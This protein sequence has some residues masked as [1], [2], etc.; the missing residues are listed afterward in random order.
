MG[1][2]NPTERFLRVALQ[3]HCS[4]CGAPPTA[5][6]STIVEEGSGGYVETCPR[7][8]LSVLPALIAD[9]LH[10]LPAG[11][12]APPAD[13]ALREIEA[14]FWRA[15]ALRLVR[16]RKEPTMRRAGN[17][18]CPCC[19]GDG[20]AR[21]NWCPICVE[22]DREGNWVRAL[23]EGEFNSKEQSQDGQ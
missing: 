18:N 9:A 8:A 16:E 7:C 17:V 19:R 13:E 10:L 6:W 1:V 12:T 11:G 4:F 22:S 2:I 23:T 21:G 14:A 15:L 5:Y 20:W 3:G